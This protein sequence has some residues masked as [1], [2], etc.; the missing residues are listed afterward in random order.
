M[1]AAGRR[2]GVELAVPLRYNMTSVRL[3]NAPSLVRDLLSDV[4]VEL[5]V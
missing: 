3:G 4:D 5:G 1:G 2:S